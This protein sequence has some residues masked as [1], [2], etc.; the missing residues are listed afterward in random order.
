MSSKYM[1]VMVDVYQLSYLTFEI[2]VY[3]VV[4]NTGHNYRYTLSFQPTC[5][6]E[7]NFNNQK[8]TMKF[9]QGYYGSGTE[10]NGL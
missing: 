5:V 1:A 2:S 9:C 8:Y 3:L 7:L 10:N 4:E 6:D